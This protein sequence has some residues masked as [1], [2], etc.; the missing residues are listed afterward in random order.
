MKGALGMERL[1]FSLKGLHR[2]GLG[3]GSSTRDPGRYVKKG[4]VYGISL[5]RGPFRTEGNLES[6]GVSY[7][8]D[9]ERWRALGTG[10]LSAKF[11]MKGTSR[12]GSPMG[13]P[14]DTLSKA[15]KW[16]SASIGALLWGNMEVP[17]FLEAL[18]LMFF[19]EMQMP[20]KRVSHP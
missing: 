20:C 19:R 11:S 18:I 3:G 9:F 13:I 1:S 7:T 10:H 16:A 6:G 17:F 4:S 5:H 12:K 15:R 8:G 2:E 14:K